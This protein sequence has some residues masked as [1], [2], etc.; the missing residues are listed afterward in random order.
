MGSRSEL[1]LLVFYSSSGSRWV[2][3]KAT[4]DHPLDEQSD[5]HSSL[6][7]SI[8]REISL[9]IAAKP[10]KIKEL[11]EGQGFEPWRGVNPCWF[12]RPVP[13][14]TRPALRSAHFRVLS[15]V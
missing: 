12:S 1:I 4:V 11:A 8:E 9:E 15:S 7:D 5:Q 3:L 6:N 14:T 2:S 13:S 10:L